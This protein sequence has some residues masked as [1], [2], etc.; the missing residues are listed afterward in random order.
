MFEGIM[1]GASVSR[2]AEPIGALAMCSGLAA[3]PARVLL[4]VPRR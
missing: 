4:W 2:R 1:D 3:V